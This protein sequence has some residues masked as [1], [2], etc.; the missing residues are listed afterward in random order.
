MRSFLRTLALLAATASTTL[1]FAQQGTHDFSAIDAIM[2]KAVTDGIIPGGVVLIGH[3]GK[4]V[5][6]KA[7]G[8]RSLEPT[9]EPM[10]ADT[11]F[12][13]DGKVRLNDPVSMYLPEFAQNGKDQ[14][15]VRELMTHYS[16]LRPDLDLKESWQGRDTAF[17][18]AMHEK[19]ANPP[20]SRFVYSDINYETLGFLVEK[21]SGEPLNQ[22]AKENV[23]ARKTPVSFPMQAFCLASHLPNTMIP[24]TCSAV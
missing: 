4:V 24:A 20:G 10:T 11:I 14:I 23:F 6:R 18:M 2:Q 21:I 19:P 5:Y 16:G 22:F 1:A 13:Q 7:F 15:T 9:H 12:I 3:N 8:S 17:Q